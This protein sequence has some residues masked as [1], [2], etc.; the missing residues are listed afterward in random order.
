MSLCAKTITANLNGLELSF[1]S[2]TGS[3]V[4]MNYGQM[5]MLKSGVENASIIDVA[6]PVPDFEPLRL[7][8]R[9]SKNAKI[10]KGDGFVEIYWDEL[11]TSRDNFKVNGKVSATVTLKEMPD[12][13]SVSAVC[14]I[15]NNSD[16]PVKQM[17]FPDFAGLLPFDGVNDTIFKTTGTS[18]RPFSEMPLNEVRNSIQFCMD[19]VN[20]QIQ[21]TV[22]GMFHSSPFRWMDFGGYSGGISMFPKLW[23]W[24]ERSIVRLHM[25]N[26][27][28]RMRL[29]NIRTKDI[30]PGESWTSEEWIFTGHKN[31]WAKG[32]EVFREYALSK[33]NRKYP[34]PKHIAEAIGFRTIWMSLSW[35]KD[36]YDTF[37]KYS[38]VPKLLKEAGDHGLSEVVAWGWSNFFELPIKG[39]DHL[40]GEQELFNNSKDAMKKYGASFTPFYS[41][42]IQIPKSAERLGGTGSPDNWTQH[43]ETIPMFQPSYSNRMTGS[44]LGPKNENW[45]KAAYSEISRIV[46]DGLTNICWDQF[47][48]MA[49]DNNMIELAKELRDKQKS[50]DPEAS[51]SG[52]ELWNMELDCELLDYTWN[53]SCGD[54]TG[55]NSVLKYPR[56]NINN[57]GDPIKA[58][59]SF[60]NNYFINAMPRKMDHPSGNEYITGINGSDYISNHKEFSDTLKDLKAVKEKFMPYFVNGTFISDCILTKRCDM[61][62][63]GT[64]VL[65]N[66]LIMLVMNNYNSTRNINMSVDLTPWIPSKSYKYKQ[67]LYDIKG[68]LVETKDITSRDRDIK[69][70]EMKYGDLLIYKFNAI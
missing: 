9:Y 68:N 10:T 27:G 51:L 19:S 33:I 56:I 15:T 12:G 67:E 66:S 26:T 30:L 46:D 16:L 37:Y 24:D 53:W 48:N 59:I 3:I 40:G 14:K 17:I 69:T 34:L 20:G 8:S 6:Y 42:L 21:Y 45:S 5:K 11:G 36:Q 22:G 62:V 58:E 52:E 55:F 65:D 39:W 57:S 63:I 35:E 49:P 60:I 29:L 70:P 28:E 25:S 47:W 32:I 7:A 2:N 31:A 54:M 23:G 43:L 4:E 18:I 13:R 64:Y 61:T 38:D 1:D 50:I 41:I 44:Y